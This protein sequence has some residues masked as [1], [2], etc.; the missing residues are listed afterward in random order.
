MADWTFI[1]F[2]TEPR[3]RHLPY[4]RCES[5][6]ALWEERIGKILQ[7]GRH[8]VVTV[9]TSNG[10]VLQN[11]VWH[12]AMKREDLEEKFDSLVAPQWGEEKTRRLKERIRGLESAKSVRPL[13]EELQG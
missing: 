5:A 11:E 3:S 12:E 4:R 9:R 7:H 8:A 13:M 2:T 6:S 1:S 10:Q